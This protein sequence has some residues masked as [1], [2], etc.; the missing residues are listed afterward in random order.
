[1]SVLLCKTGGEIKQSN[2]TERPLLVDGYSYLVHDDVA[3]ESLREG[4]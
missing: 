2:L 3:D 4:G 1:M